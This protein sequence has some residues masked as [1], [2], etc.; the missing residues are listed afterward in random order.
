MAIIPLV[1]HALDLHRE[2]EALPSIRLEVRLAK[3]LLLVSLIIIQII[4]DETFAQIKDRVQSS[5]TLIIE[6]NE[7]KNMSRD[8]C[9][10]LLSYFFV[11][12]NLPIKFYTSL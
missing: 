5:N 8:H 10:I 2:L 9:K 6:S 3:L 7:L 4:K 12:F 1:C 11:T